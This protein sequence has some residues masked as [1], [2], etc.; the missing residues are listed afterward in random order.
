MPPL[1]GG[2]I[3]APFQDTSAEVS[4]GVGQVIGYSG[5]DSVGT[6]ASTPDG[7]SIHS[8]S[9]NPKLPQ[10]SIWFISCFSA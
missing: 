3:G 10:H 2:L 9:Q 5:E 7:L 4:S 6:V 1:T 8:I